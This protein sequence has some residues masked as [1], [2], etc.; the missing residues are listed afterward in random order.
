MQETI[1]EKQR[2]ILKKLGNGAAF[3]KKK[4]IEIRLAV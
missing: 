3:R 2:N 1:L 4:E